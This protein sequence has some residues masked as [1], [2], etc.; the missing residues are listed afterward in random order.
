MKNTTLVYKSKNSGT[1]RKIFS[2][3]VSYGTVE[4]FLVMEG[5]LGISQHKAAIVSLENLL[6]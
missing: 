3:R 5:K 4:Q 2:G 1:R 6:S